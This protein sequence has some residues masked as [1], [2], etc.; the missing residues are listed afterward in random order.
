[1]NSTW[2]QVRREVRA[3][4]NSLQTTNF[5]NIKDFCFDD[6]NNRAYF[7]AIDPSR[8]KTATL[9]Y[10]NLP[11]VKNE[12][13]NEEIDEDNSWT[14][15]NGSTDSTNGECHDSSFS[16]NN[17]EFCVKEKP[18]SD[19]LPREEM[20]VKERRRLGLH[21]ITNFQFD[22]RS[23]HL[24]FSYGSG[25]YLGQNKEFYPRPILPS[26]PFSSG[27]IIYPGSIVNLP[28]T[29][30]QIPNSL[31]QQPEGLSPLPLPSNTGSLLSSSSLCC[32]SF[33][34]IQPPR[35]D[36]KLGGRNSNLVAFIRDR[37]IW[38]TTLNGCETQLTFCGEQDE[39]LSCGVAEFVMQEEFHQNI[40]RILYLQIS[41]S[42]VDLVLIP[43]PEPLGEIEEYRYPKAASDLQIVEFI[44]R[45]S[46]EEEATFGPVHKRLWGP[47]ALNKLFPWMEY[48]VR[49][50]WHPNGKSVW[51]Q[52][53]DRSQ[54]RTA[55]VKIPIENFTSFSQYREYQKSG[56]G[57]DD[58][59][60]SRV[61]L[62]FEE[63][64]DIWINVEKPSETSTDY[65]V[66]SITAGDWPIVD[67][68]IY[69][70]TKRELVYFTAKKDTPLENHL[71]V[72]S[73]AKGADP[74]N[75]VR[76]T[77]IGYSHVVVLDEKCS[78]YLDWFSN[79]KEKPRCGVRYLEWSKNTIFPKTSETL[80]L[81]IRRGC[82]EE[83]EEEEEEKEEREESEERKE[84]GE[85]KKEEKEEEKKGE[86]E[87]TKDRRGKCPPLGE[88]FNFKNSDGIT[89][90]GYLYKPENYVPGKKYPTLLS[91][92]G[93]P[94]SQ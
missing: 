11:P 65:H 68:P 74:S 31:P 15:I 22:S 2:E 94:K 44:P 48:I 64:N 5:H 35:L 78:R 89:I 79:V 83:E 1:M 86:K 60:I 57:L 27:P 75:V 58:L 87:E 43:R 14:L 90:Y 45:Y 37:D 7:L 81:F 63:T 25:I 32:S 56:Q 10:V 34:N 61:E 24:L 51:V 38:V 20:F 71:Y 92:Y 16:F 21:G 53:L 82:E 4:R 85:E 62:L 19:S 54:K 40:E 46:E 84:K 66:R 30:S 39:A 36:P 9:F 8:K 69:V 49:F 47:T 67:R 73:Y 52:F 18:L 23:G 41:E 91:I 88:F 28:I 77:E 6:K 59:C 42:M 50:G 33:N 3:Y 12:V 80:G 17:S 76:L 13:E 93:G 55:V 29:Y 26:S 72:A 70:D